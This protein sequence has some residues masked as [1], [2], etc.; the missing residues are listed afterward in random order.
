MLPVFLTAS[1]SGPDYQRPFSVDA[2]KIDQ[3]LVN[4]MTSNPDDAT[5]VRAVIRIG[6]SLWLC[7]SPYRRSLATR[8]AFLY[9]HP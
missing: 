7:A 4:P 2:L 5:V 9:S 8:L 3:P 1:Y 6:R